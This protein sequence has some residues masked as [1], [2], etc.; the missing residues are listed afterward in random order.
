[1]TPPPLPALKTQPGPR[2]RI[3]R[4]RIRPWAPGPGPRP[5]IQSSLEK[6][7]TRVFLYTTNTG[8]CYNIGF[9]PKNT[10]FPDSRP[11]CSR[12]PFSF[13]Q[14][15]ENGYF[16]VLQLASKRVLSCLAFAF[17]CL[18]LRLSL[19]YFV[20]CLFTFH[21]LPFLCLSL[22]TCVPFLTCLVPFLNCP[23]PALVPLLNCLCT[24]RGLVRCLAAPRQ[25][26]YYGTNSLISCTTSILSEVG[27]W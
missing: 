6:N 16:L 5:K 14:N 7:T 11:T 4:L 24:V 21:C 1:M 22:P 19:H 17:A 10:H 20:A 15:R 12:P 8:F 18:H 3:R 26:Y 23:L 25:L 2:G 13:F 9:L 27:G